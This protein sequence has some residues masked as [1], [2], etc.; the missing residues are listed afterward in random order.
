MKK[1]LLAL[2]LLWLWNPGTGAAQTRIDTTGGRYYR[3]IFATVTRTQDVTYGAATDFLGNNQNLRLD[4]YQPVGDT[5]RRRPLLVFAHGGGFVSG[6]RSDA[7]IVE[8]CTRFARMGYVTASID[9][10]LLFLPFDTVNIG[11]AAIRATQDM[12]AAVRFFRRDAATT[13]AYRIHPGFIYA[14]GSSA[15]AFMALQTG[16]LDKDSEVPAYLGL[17]ALGGLEGSSGNPG[18]ASNVQGVINLCG[19]LG[20]PWWIEAGNVPFVSLHGTA[21][22]VVPYGAGTVGS[23]LPP[24]KVYGSAVLK[25]RATAVGVVNPLYTFKGAGHV[26]YNGSSATAAAYLDTTTRFVRDFLR[27][28]LRQP[29]TVTAVKASAATAPQV[30]PVPATDAIRVQWPAAQLFRRQPAELLDVTGRIVR[31]LRWE[32]PELLVL[33]ENL[34]AGTYLLRTEGLASR[35][36]VFD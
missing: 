4:V 34:P 18:Y 5:V 35:R 26:P 1:L 29:A 12:R 33:R 14:G 28:L 17:A 9:Y 13:R 21:D 16:Y 23:G 22:A 11:R 15:G 8:L 20:R 6:N 24:Q 7:E 2:V 25:V 27:P 10:R 32:Q 3:P 31:R 19:A 30:F 36:V